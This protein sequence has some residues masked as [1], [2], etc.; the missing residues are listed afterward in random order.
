MQMLDRVA[1]LQSPN[2]RVVIHMHGKYPANAAQQAKAISWSLRSAH[3]V[4]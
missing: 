4:P 1:L 2:C 3:W